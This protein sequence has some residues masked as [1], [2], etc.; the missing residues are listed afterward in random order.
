M[1]FYLGESSNQQDMVALGIPLDVRIDETDARIGWT[2]FYE[3]DDL[4]VATDEA[5]RTRGYMRGPYSYCGHPGNGW[6]TTDKNCRGDATTV[7][8]K[9]LTRQ[10]FNQS[11]EY[12]FRYKSVLNYDPELKWQLDYVE[13]VPVD[14]VD[15]DFY[16]EDWY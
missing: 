12:W 14:V 15:N 8:R 7:L 2:K 6:N 4:G 11:K 9:I 3:E 1:Q 16:A 5:L 10:T 13:F